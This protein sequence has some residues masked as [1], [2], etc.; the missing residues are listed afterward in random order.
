MSKNIYEMLNNVNIDLD[1]LKNEE[2]TDFDKSKVNKNFRKSLNKYGSY[3]KYI[4]I[5][6]L[7][8]ISLCI[9]NKN[10]VSYA[11]EVIEDIGYS[12]SEVLGLQSN[13]EDY[14][15]IINKSV[16]KNNMDVTINEVIL[17][18]DEIVFSYTVESDKK[19]D[20]IGYENFSI[21]SLSINNKDL[22]A[23]GSGN[24]EYIDEHTV[25]NVMRFT[26]FGIDED[27]LNGEVKIKIKFNLFENGKI[28]GQP[29]VF[30]FK[31]DGKQLALDT[32]EIKMNKTIELESGA[33]LVLEKYTKNDM[34]E[35][36]YAR[37]DNYDD[38]KYYD[39]KIKGI[40]KNGLDVLF[41]MSNCSADNPILERF[42]LDSKLDSRNI[43]FSIYVAE[44]ES[45][46]IPFDSD[47]KEVCSEF[48]IE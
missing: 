2:F 1:E 43:K 13:L 23:A 17:N 6:S 12:I 36:I 34:G 31:A 19:L 26:L 32:Y 33:R 44:V 35:K 10:F 20:E 21:S 27:E 28:K 5:A 41:T 40:D 7:L 37:I 8:I 47:F 14:T 9:L 18:N 29:W 16:S 30:K 46:Y 39:I 15:T 42:Y 22:G 3:K 24:P 11:K 45:G 48:I 38:S 25:K 4:S